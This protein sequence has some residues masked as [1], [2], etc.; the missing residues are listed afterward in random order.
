[1]L[2]T[3]FSKFDDLVD[4][5]GL[6]KIK[7]IGDCYMV[8]SG[9]PNPRDD[10]AAAL[11]ALT[12]ELGNVMDAYAEECG[13]SITFRS[14]IHSGPVTAGVIG[15]RKFAFDVWGDTVNIASRM[16]SHGIPGKLQIS[17][18]THRLVEDQFQ[19]EPRGEIAVKGKG[20]MRTWIV[21]GRK[22]ASCETVGRG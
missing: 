15:K 8:A 3:I 20:M 18:E 6:E 4:Q 12:L 17:D 19:C 2:N 16:E 11:V 14:G 5:F 22:D 10:H 7:T 21:V 1:M 9:L 13:D